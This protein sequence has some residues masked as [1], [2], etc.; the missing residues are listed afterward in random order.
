M[1]N[2]QNTQ[3]NNPSVSL[4]IKG[5]VTFSSL[6][7]P[8]TNQ[9]GQSQYS[10]TLENPQF[11][12]PN[13]NPLTADMINFIQ[14]Q[15]GLVRPGNEQ[16]PN[17]SIAVYLR[18]TRMDG[19]PQRPRYFDRKSNSEIPVQH[20][21]ARGVTVEAVVSARKS[22][23]SQQHGVVLYLN[24]VIF[25]DA[26][27][28]GIWYT[29]N[30][31]IAGFTALPDSG[32]QVTNAPTNQPA[33]NNAQVPPFNNNTTPANPWQGAQS[34]TPQT[35]AG[36]GMPQAGNPQTPQAPMGGN[37]TAGNASQNGQTN[38]TNPWE[39]AGQ[40]TGNQQAPQSPMG[41]NPTAGQNPNAGNGNAGVPNGNGANP[42]NPWQSNGNE[43]QNG[44]ANNSNG[45]EPQNGNNGGLTNPWA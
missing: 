6:A 13:N 5:Q 24:G 4:G 1:T 14:T 9:Y 33:A 7:K 19:T 31:L 30:P 28:P 3:Q 25:D 18:S 11:I 12:N 34:A 17:P 26:N 27:Q 16:Y 22:S 2:A 15:S 29:Q 42:T 39:G 38:L 44:N 45:N 32:T 37:Q 20:N 43:G 23:R 35:Q 36:A 41:T 40:S 8:E 21:I 10:L